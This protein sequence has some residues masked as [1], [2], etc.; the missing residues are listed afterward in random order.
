MGLCYC[1]PSWKGKHCSIYDY[2][3]QDSYRD[4]RTLPFGP[5]PYIDT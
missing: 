3:Y 4:N 2:K 1:N 5:G